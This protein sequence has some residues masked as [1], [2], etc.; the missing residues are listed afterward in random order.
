MSRQGKKRAAVMVRRESG[1]CLMYMMYIMMAFRSSSFCA[2]IEI[3]LVTTEAVSFFGFGSGGDKMTQ[4]DVS[5]ERIGVKSISLT[6]SLS[7][8]LTVF[9]HEKEDHSLL[10]IWSS[11]SV[12]I[13][14]NNAHLELFFG[15][16][17]L[18]VKREY[19]RWK[20]KLF[21]LFGGTE[22]LSFN[23]NV[24]TDTCFGIHVSRSS[25]I[26]LKVF[27]YFLNFFRLFL[28]ITGVTLFFY[29]WRLCR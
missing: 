9:C 25:T 24:F 29:S 14:A 27:R 11:I 2:I 8:G 28:T 4:S 16:S 7:A 17:S 3:M 26:Q 21:S 5:Y 18:E 22:K 6:K 13:Q 10:L 19:E 15:N 12:E 23:L 20:K 1:I